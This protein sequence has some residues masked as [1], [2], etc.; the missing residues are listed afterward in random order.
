MQDS[1]TIDYGTNGQI[2]SRRSAF[3]I[4]VG[5]GELNETEYIIY[6]RR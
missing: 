4:E 5:T 6:M 2:Y 3:F 1:I